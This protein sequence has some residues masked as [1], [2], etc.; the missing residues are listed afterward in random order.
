[1]LCKA[2]V[3]PLESHTTRVQWVCS[4]AENG[5]LAAVVKRLGIKNLKQNKAQS[6]PAE[7]TDRGVN[8]RSKYVTQVRQQKPGSP[9]VTRTWHACKYKVHQLH[10]TWHAGKYKVHKLCQRYILKL[11]YIEDVLLEQFMYLYLHVCQV[12]V[13]VGDSGLCCVLL[14]CISS[15]N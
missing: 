1:M 4:E 14:L 6:T 2:A 8:Y 7:S 12:R 9:T 3:T 10:T 5:A 11:R 15:A 13:T